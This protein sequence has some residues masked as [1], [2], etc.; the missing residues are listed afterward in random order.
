MNFAATSLKGL[1]WHPNEGAC[2]QDFETTLHPYLS[3]QHL[4]GVLTFSVLWNKVTY[5][6]DTAIGDSP[7]IIESFF[8]LPGSEDHRLYSTLRSFI[9]K[10]YVQVL[11]RNKVT[12]GSRELF[13][14]PTISQVHEGWC[15]R[16]GAATDNFLTKRFGQERRRY[17]TSFDRLLEDNPGA[18]RRYDPNDAKP[19]FRK[20]ISAALENDEDFRTMVTQLPKDL[21]AKYQRT[22]HENPL[23]TTV[24]LWRIVRT[25]ADSLPAAKA[26]LVAQG[27][28]NQ[29]AI[30]AAVAAAYA[31]SDDGQGWR[32]SRTAVPSSAPTSIEAL[33]E[34]ADHTLTVPAIEVLGAIS[35]DDVAAIRRIA[36][37]ILFSLT[38]PAGATSDQI[39]DI[40]A[41]GTKDY[42][43]AV[44]GY[45]D[46]CYPQHTRLKRT[47]YAYIDRQIRPLKRLYS[48][49]GYARD[50]VEIATS[51]ALKQDTSG[52]TGLARPVAK[53]LGLLLLYRESQALLELKSLQSSLWRPKSAWVVTDDNVR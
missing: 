19:L 27:Y 40:T 51:L 37:R 30:A 24:D 44:C 39:R 32:P 45:I 36:D 33:L 3:P 6:Y 22:C 41:R 26:L 11:I 29:Q 1:R 48:K 9:E 31:G 12:V 52:T 23:M 34:T 18:I 8:A 25:L 47:A 10:G 5:V 17:N 35:P 4:L 42:W 50:V 15:I 28:V 16:D 14:D 43:D 53:R 7:S 38:A 13:V 21:S 49:S 2:L 20:V 46:T